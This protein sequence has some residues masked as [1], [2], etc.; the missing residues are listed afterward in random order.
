MYVAEDKLIGR[1]ISQAAEVCAW[2][3]PDKRREMEAR[4][5]K[6]VDMELVFAKF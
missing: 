4:D 1:G 6:T 3:R 2:Q 5:A